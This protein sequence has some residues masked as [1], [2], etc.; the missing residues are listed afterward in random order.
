MT[1]EWHK[2]QTGLL[3]LETEHKY[4]I[5]GDFAIKSQNIPLK[6]KVGNSPSSPYLKYTKLLNPIKLII[7]LGSKHH[8][9]KTM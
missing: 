6:L 3:E 4:L 9:F 7:K 8:I 2:Q 1:F 5:C